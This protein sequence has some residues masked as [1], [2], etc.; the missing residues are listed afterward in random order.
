MKFTKVPDH[1]SYVP[2]NIR[3]NA[4]AKGITINAGWDD[5]G[6]LNLWDQMFHSDPLIEMSLDLDPQEFFEGSS[7]FA[8]CDDVP[9]D[10]HVRSVS[11]LVT[12]T[13]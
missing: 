3:N 11:R 1:L 2:K 6:L 10:S 4:I 12:A 8:V 7:R 13:T 9:P 5:V